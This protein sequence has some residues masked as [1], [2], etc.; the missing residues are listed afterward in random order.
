MSDVPRKPVTTTPTD[1][2]AI[3]D[4]LI[5]D[6]ILAAQKTRGNLA[7]VSSS[8]TLMVMLCINFGEALN[9]LELRNGSFS[10]FSE[11]EAPSLEPLTVCTSSTKGGDLCRPTPRKTWKEWRTKRKASHCARRNHRG[12]RQSAVQNRS[13]V[14]ELH[15]R[16]LARME[17]MGQ[18]MWLPKDP[19]LEEIHPIS[20][21]EDIPPASL[22]SQTSATPMHHLSL[23]SQKTILFSRD[24]MQRLLRTRK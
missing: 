16:L 7:Q 13:L 14:M 1:A 9:N 24:H 8:G 21:N 4:V 20:S 2:S 22:S 3:V 12:V 15:L 5:E 10:A 18:L 19:S 23:S 11:P 17:S 6:D